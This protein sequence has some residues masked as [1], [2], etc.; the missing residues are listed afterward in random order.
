MKL[1][2]IVWML[3]IFTSGSAFA[4]LQQR[5]CGPLYGGLSFIFNQGVRPSAL[6][7]KF[8]DLPWARQTY[9]S[10][11]FA[12]EKTRHASFYAR[13]KSSPLYSYTAG[14]SGIDVPIGSEEFLAAKLRATGLVHD[15]ALQWGD[16][17]GAEIAYFSLGDLKDQKNLILPANFQKAMGK[18]STDYA[19]SKNVLGLTS[20]G[21]IEVKNFT[22]F[23]IEPSL[24]LG[25]IRFRVASEI[26]RD[27]SSNA[28][29]DQFDAVFSLWKLRNANSFVTV[30]IENYKNAPRAGRRVPPSAEHFRQVDHDNSW[31]DEAVIS[32]SI[33]AFF[34]NYFDGKCVVDG[35][36]FGSGDDG[37]PFG[38]D[39]SYK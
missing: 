32:S 34:A 5:E 4:E 20:S 3:I 16:C 6:A 7:S 30:S 11:E 38:C 1:A 28:T 2:A 33:A 22:T 27:R 8:K 12:E 9:E 18:A 10:Y 26:S 36:G 31:D 25:R 17:G 23:P 19:K 24:P 39:L 15:V 35:E 13:L 37:N 14:A 29:W 21:E